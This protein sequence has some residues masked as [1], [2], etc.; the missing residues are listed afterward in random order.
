MSADPIIYCLEQISD[1]RGFERLCSALLAGADYPE[2]D[3]LGGT[4]DGGRDAIIRNDSKGRRICFAYSVRSDWRTKLGNDCKRVHE[5]GHK[6]DVFVFVCIKGLSA[7]EKD[8]AHKFVAGNYGWT[9]D[10][11]DLERLRTQLV[12]PQRHLV[13]QHPSIFTPAL[14]LQKGDQSIVGS[15]DM[16]QAGNSATRQFVEILPQL[17]EKY[18]KYLRPEMTSVQFVQSRDRCHL[19]ITTTDRGSGDLVDET[20]KRTDLVFVSGGSGAFFSPGSPITENVRRFIS[21]FDEVSIINCTDLFTNEAA[22]RIDEHW[23]RY[24]AVPDSL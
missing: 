22:A 11:F 17:R 18:P 2:I 1:Y 3:P 12:G 14:F 21:D 6:P 23:R 19:E 9:L 7:S 10:L 16:L 4:G 13:H 20:S 24:S 15:R 5:K 8:F